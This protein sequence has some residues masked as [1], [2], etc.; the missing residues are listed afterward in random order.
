MLAWPLVAQQ[1]DYRMPVI[2]G[3]NWPVGRDSRSGKIRIAVAA[4]ALRFLHCQPPNHGS[5]VVKDHVH[6]IPDSNFSTTSSFSSSATRC[7]SAKTLPA[8]GNG[9]DLPSRRGRGALRA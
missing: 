6:S 5:D 3:S 7:R 8:I 2:L 4:P 1:F 9:A